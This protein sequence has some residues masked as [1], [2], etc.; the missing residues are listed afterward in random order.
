MLNIK[1]KQ[2]R[3]FVFGLIGLGVIIAVQ[4]YMTIL[5]GHR[6][7]WFI[8]GFFLFFF[9][10]S[11]DV[12]ISLV[13]D[14]IIYNC[15]KR[16]EGIISGKS[17]FTQLKYKSL[18][19]PIGIFFVVFVGVMILFSMLA[20]V[21]KEWLILCIYLTVFVIGNFIFM[22]VKISLIIKTYTKHIEELICTGIDGSKK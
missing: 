18:P 15:F 16:L 10:Y 12:F 7:D 6:R 22:G 2:N 5:L 4:L 13:V 17:D 21:E 11:V 3:Q 19:G 20:A 9:I 1:N 14:M 8:M